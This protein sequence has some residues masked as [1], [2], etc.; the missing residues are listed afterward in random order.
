MTGQGPSPFHIWPPC[1]SYGCCLPIIWLPCISYGNH[2]SLM[3]PAIQRHISL[4][5]TLSA[6]GSLASHVAAA[7]LSNGYLVFFL[8]QPYLSHAAISIWLSNLST[9]SYASPTS[10]VYSEHSIKLP[11][12]GWHSITGA[13][14]ILPI[15]TPQKT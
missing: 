1:I 8:R 3:I 6:Y 14:K 11:E 13:P 9:S 4:C 2:T 5:S 12:E 7:L 15:L 10:L